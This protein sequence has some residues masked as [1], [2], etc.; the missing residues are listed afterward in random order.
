MFSL[1]GACSGVGDFLMPAH[2]LESWSPN[3]YPPALSSS[4]ESARSRSLSP[5]LLMIVSF[6]PLSDLKDPGVVAG[7][8]TGK[9]FTSSNRF[10]CNVLVFFPLSPFS[11]QMAYTGLFDSCFFTTYTAFSQ[12]DRNFPGPPRSSTFRTS[13]QSPSFSTTPIIF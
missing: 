5:I 13:A 2:G 8:S 12:E 6:F 3:Q 10:R 1:I 9:S 7:G 4:S 11:G